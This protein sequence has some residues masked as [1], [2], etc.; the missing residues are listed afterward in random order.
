[1]CVPQVIL[2]AGDVV[3]CQGWHIGKSHASCCHQSN[4]HQSQHTSDLRLSSLYER[5]QFLKYLGTKQAIYDFNRQNQFLLVRNILVPI[6]FVH[7]RLAPDSVL[8]YICRRVTMD[9]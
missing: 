6:T 9:R 7:S 3:L 2:L 4:L 5:R 8:I 1:M